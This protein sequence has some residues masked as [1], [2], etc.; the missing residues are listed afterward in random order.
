LTDVV[1]VLSR[2]LSAVAPSGFLVLEE[3][4]DLRSTHPVFQRY[5]AI[6]ER[7]QAHYGQAMYIGRSLDGLC[8]AGGWTI[9]SA[10]TARL[11]LPA[12]RMARLHALNL[13]TWSKDPFVRGEYTQGELS[14]VGSALE[15]I[16]GSDAASP[17]ECAMRQVVVE[18]ALSQIGPT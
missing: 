17:V 16:A 7:M 15:R 14:D 12:A 10:T 4:A 8:Q 1:Q 11:A 2:W 3:T 13:Q 9:R 5:Y 18:P 6:V